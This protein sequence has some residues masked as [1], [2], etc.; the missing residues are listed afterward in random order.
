MSRDKYP[1]VGLFKKEKSQGACEVCKR[2]GRD[3]SVRV[4]WD[5]MRGNDDFYYFCKEC[6]PIFMKWFW[7]S[8]EKKEGYI[9]VNTA[10]A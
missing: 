8:E 1:N 9:H 3:Y 6:R 4:Q 10:T 2:P 7:S 5:W